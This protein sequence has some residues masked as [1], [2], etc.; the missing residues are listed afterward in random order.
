MVRPKKF[1][2]IGRE[3]EIDYFKPRGIPLSELQEINLEIEEYEALRLT[4]IESY[5]QTKA[6]ELMNISQPTFHRILDLAR[7]KISDAIVNGKAIRIEGGKFKIA[8]RKFKC[9]DCQHEWE[10][11]FGT[12]RPD[13]CPK[14]GSTNLHRVN[15]DTG[16]LGHHGR[17]GRGQFGQGRGQRFR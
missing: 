15:V 14:C 7:K 12:G 13:K 10:I 2:L 1:R 6:A 17:R 5:D 8:K 11:A 16:R 4:D 9:F 3:P